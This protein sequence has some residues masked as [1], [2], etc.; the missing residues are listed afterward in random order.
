[1]TNNIHISIAGGDKVE[2]IK[3][4]NSC[5]CVWDLK[6]GYFVCSKCGKKIKK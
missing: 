3:I 6:N 2:H 4:R 1:M 5:D